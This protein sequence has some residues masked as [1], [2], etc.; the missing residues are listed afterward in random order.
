MTQIFANVSK[1]FFC[2]HLLL[3]IETT[4]FFQRSVGFANLSQQRTSVLSVD[5]ELLVND[6]CYSRKFDLNLHSALKKF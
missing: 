1:T 6:Y 2:S 3:P 4:K 5:R